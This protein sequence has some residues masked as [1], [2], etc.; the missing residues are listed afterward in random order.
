[1]YEVESET[2]IFVTEGKGRVKKSPNLHDVIIGR[3]LRSLDTAIKSDVIFET[4]EVY[5]TK[6]CKRT[7]TRNSII[8][9][10]N[11]PD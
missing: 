10:A 11:I 2:P 5:P 7:I 8:S 1:M 6:P 3:P 4:P 9:G